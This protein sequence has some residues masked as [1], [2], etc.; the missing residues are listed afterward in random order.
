MF[1]I[2]CWSTF[3]LSGL[4]IGS[5]LMVNLAFSVL[6]STCFLFGECLVDCARR[7]CVNWLKLADGVGYCD[8]LLFWLNLDSLLEDFLVLV[9][10]TDFCFG[11]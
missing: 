2:T 7:L 5:A 8:R 10:C 4:S 1:F 6:G 11:V 3:F 9:S